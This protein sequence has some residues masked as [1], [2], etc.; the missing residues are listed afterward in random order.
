MLSGYL[1]AKLDRFLLHAMNTLMHGLLNAEVR[2]RIDA[3]MLARWEEKAQRSGN[4]LLRFGAKYYSQNDEDGIL[5]EIVRRIRLQ[6]GSFAEIG[7]GNGLQNNTIILLMHGWRGLWVGAEELRFQTE[8]SSRL[9][10]LKEWVVPETIVDT[11]SRGL[12]ALQLQLASLDVMSVDID[13]FDY[14]VVRQMLEHRIFPKVLIVEYNAKFPPPIEFSLAVGETWEVGTDY[15]GCS[16][17]SWWNLLTPAGYRLVA[18]NV[19]GVNAFFVRSDYTELFND[20]PSKIEDL[21]VPC[22][23]NWFVQV[24]H[25]PSPKTLQRFL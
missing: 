16:L 15:T 24:G 7:V 6:G 8:G 23:Y 1:R 3:V 25:R 11:L 19:T 14:F 13:S 4:A 12:A 22:D 21:F 5:L 10:F 2:R 9:K 18:C 17:Q 20:V